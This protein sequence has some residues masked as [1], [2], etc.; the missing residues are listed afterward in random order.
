MVLNEGR[1]ENEMRRKAR[2]KDE[3]RLEEKEQEDED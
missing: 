1:K 2:V 3:V